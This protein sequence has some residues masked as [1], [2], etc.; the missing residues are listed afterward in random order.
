MSK[1]KDKEILEGILQEYPPT[2][3]HI[4]NDWEE[5]AEHEDV[6]AIVRQ[7]KSIVNDKVPALDMD[8][9]VRCQKLRDEFQ[10]E[11]E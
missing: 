10:K 8:L 3:P 2:N 7:W 4:L 5:Q 11:E 6:K 9:F 1:I